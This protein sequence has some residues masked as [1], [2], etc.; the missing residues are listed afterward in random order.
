MLATV[1]AEPTPDVPCRAECAMPDESSMSNRPNLKSGH[2]SQRSIHI[3]LRAAL[4]SIA[5]SRAICE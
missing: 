1:D 3:P 5:A 4:H 2:R